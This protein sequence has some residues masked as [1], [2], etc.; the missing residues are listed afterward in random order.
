M[1]FLSLPPTSFLSKM[2]EKTNVRNHFLTATVGFPGVAVHHGGGCCGMVRLPF[3]DLVIPDS[4][5]P[6]RRVVGVFSRDKLGKKGHAGSSRQGGVRSK[7]STCA[8]SLSPVVLK[9]TKPFILKQ[10]GKKKQQI[11]RVM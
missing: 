2:W 8:G 7:G 3:R 4:R 11:V 6:V 9:K 5:A 10:F 1:S